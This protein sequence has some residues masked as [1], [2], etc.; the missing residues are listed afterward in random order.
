MDANNNIDKKETQ[1]SLQKCST[2]SKKR[3]S[4]YITL[5]DFP[6]ASHLESCCE[7]QSPAQ[8]KTPKDSE[9]N[10][11]IQTKLRKLKKNTTS[12]CRSKFSWGASFDTTAN[13][14]ENCE[15]P[16]RLKRTSKGR[17]V[18]KK[19]STSLSMKV[20]SF[21]QEKRSS[22]NFIPKDSRRNSERQ[23]KSKSTS[24]LESRSPRDILNKSQSNFHLNSL[25]LFY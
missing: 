13:Q 25:Y 20:E 21:P 16:L 19:K 14:S 23:A 15:T 3:V 7:S 6:Y 4:K 12:N 10:L 5:L 24:N 17:R 11:N 22:L 9:G 8:I 2:L 18:S 1:G